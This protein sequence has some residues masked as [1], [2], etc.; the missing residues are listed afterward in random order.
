MTGKLRVAHVGEFKPESANGVHSAVAGLTSHLSSV[1]VDVQIWHCSK[2]VT[3]VRERWVGEGVK[4][5]DIPKHPQFT[6]NA[7]G[8]PR[9]SWKVLKGLAADVD[10]LH[11]HSV[12]TPENIA[13]GRLGVPYVV[14]PH[15]GYNRNVTC[16]RRRFAKA[17]WRA[18]WETGFLRSARALHAVSE[19]EARDL[20]ALGVNRRIVCVP[21]GLGDEW[22]DEQ[23]PC[24]PMGPW[25]F[26]GRLDVEA[27]GLDLLLD[28]YAAALRMSP[29]PNLMLVGPDHRGGQVWLAQRIADL[30]L[31]GN[32]E[33]RPP[34]FGRAKAELLRSASAV[35]HPS[36]WEGLPFG[37][38]EALAVGRPV[39][40]TPG[41]NMASVVAQYEAGIA[42]DATPAGVS[43]GLF[44][45]AEHGPAWRAAA[46]ERGRALVLERFT[47][48]RVASQVAAMYREVL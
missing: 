11:F 48:D 39:L 28:G 36:R 3:A 30:G 7:F 44:M 16:G 15:G 4:I 47:W 26:L 17:V 34:I 21:N 27:K 8:L 18:I 31:A 38:L 46:G 20:E 24:P 13:L 32:V 6:R 35:L 5:V 29:L 1:D 2:K 41:T 12:Y 42:V 14:S 23:V 19:G 9:E 40:V 25:V 37:V 10:L 45:L 33:I 43:E 22:L